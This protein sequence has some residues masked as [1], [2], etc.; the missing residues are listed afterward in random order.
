MSS[1]RKPKPTWLKLVTGNPG[2]RPLN[3]AEPQLAGDLSEAPPPELVNDAQRAIWKRV[4]ED[5]PYLRAADR[6]ILVAFC[7]AADS[8]YKASQKCEEFGVVVADPKTRKPMKSPFYRIR[9]EQARAMKE[10]GSE[11]GLSPVSRSRVSVA[12][13]NPS[14][15]APTAFDDL[16]ELPV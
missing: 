9:S 8:F 5:A 16:K 7:V 4:L 12:R 1:G 11:I 2:R 13:A 6:D 3:D 15:K 14:P 10:F